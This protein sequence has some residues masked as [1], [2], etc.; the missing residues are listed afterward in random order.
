VGFKW[1]S[2]KN[3]LLEKYLIKSTRK[4]HS[5]GQSTEMSRPR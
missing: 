4:G 1:I 2:I 5:E 3:T